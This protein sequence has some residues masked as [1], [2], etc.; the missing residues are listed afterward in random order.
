MKP[1]FFAAFRRQQL[2]NACDRCDWCDWAEKPTEMLAFSPND[3]VTKFGMRSVTNC[4]LP[5]QAS[6]RSQP[7]TL[8]SHH[9]VSRADGENTTENRGNSEI[10]TRSQRS[11]VKTHGNPPTKDVVPDSRHPLKPPEVGAKIE[12]IESE[13]RAKGWPAELLWN[14][15]FWNCPRG[16]AAVLDADD[17]IAEITPD[18]IAILRCR[19]DIHRFRRHV[20]RASTAC[21]L[22]PACSRV[23]TAAAR[24][25]C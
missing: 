14:A 7:V 23:P 2:A 16:L 4:D 5:V 24:T 13:A 19:R 1:D 10:V 15:Y 21:F 8:L 25:D 6:W 3:A 20:R 9:R 18:Y 22:T 11:Q 12:A 17:E